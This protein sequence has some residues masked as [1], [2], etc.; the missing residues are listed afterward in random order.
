MWH[1]RL[2]A[3]WTKHVKTRFLHC[4]HN[5]NVLSKETESLSKTQG[6]IMKEN[7]LEISGAPQV[8]TL[9]DKPLSYT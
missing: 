4:L 9:H 3:Q 6:T 8:S 1:L 2:G 7:G 5:L